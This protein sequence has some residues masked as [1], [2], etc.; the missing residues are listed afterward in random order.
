MILNQTSINE[1]QVNGVVVLRNIITSHWLEKLAVGVKRNFENPSKYKCVYEIKDSNELF[2]D[3]YCNWQRIKEY[4]DF[5]FNS[6][7]ATIAA[8]LMRSQKVNLFHEHVL[9]KEPGTTKKN[10]LASGS[11]VL[12]CQWKR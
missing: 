11:I 8:Q 12:L 10:A 9:I 4:K 6:K 2:F 3:D 1:Y 5:F 7:I